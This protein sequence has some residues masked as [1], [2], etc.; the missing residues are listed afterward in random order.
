MAFATLDAAVEVVAVFAGEQPREVAS[1][2][3]EILEARSNPAEE[4]IYVVA[5]RDD[6]DFSGVCAEEAFER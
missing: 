3:G 6:A 2:G 5:F 1:A 4:F